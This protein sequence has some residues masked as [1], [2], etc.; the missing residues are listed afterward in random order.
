MSAA[1]ELA[2]SI[3]EQLSEDSSNFN[4]FSIAKDLCVLFNLE[5]SNP[6][7]RNLLF[8]AVE[9][10]EKFGSSAQV[11]DGLLRRVGLFP[12]LSPDSLSFADL[13]AY[14]ANR[15]EGFQENIVFHRAQSLVFRL[16]MEGQNVALSA[17]TSFGKS[18]IVDGIVASNKFKNIVI[19]VPTLALIDETRKR[20]TQ[21]FGNRYKIITQVGQAKADR[22]IF[23]FTQER[24]LDYPDLSGTDFFV[25]DEFY[26]LLPKGKSDARSHLLNNAFYLLAKTGAQFYMLGPNI[27]GLAEQDHLS[28]DIRFINEPNFHTV[29]TKVH[30]YNG[31]LDPVLATIELCKL[32]DSQTIIF[33]RS[34]NRAIEVTKALI[35]AGVGTDE[36]LQP[37]A[38]AWVGESYHPEWHFAKA[39]SRGIGV[40]HGSGEGGNKE[41]YAYFCLDTV[42]Q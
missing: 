29:A 6:S 20:L 24:V 32:I 22:N 13:L 39:L 26:K 12:Y 25:I 15:P 18:L 33:C 7:C 11:L 35:E 40:H 28:I 2:K 37:E 27:L 34:P 21:R 36:D 3:A 10:R 30:R 9:L 1:D 17:P 14:E 23:V 5:E 19:V 38:S 4:G 41:S 16:L 31:K 8:Q 42:V